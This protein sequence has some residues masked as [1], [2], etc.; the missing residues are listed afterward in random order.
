[1]CG[2]MRNLLKISKNSE[3]Q[4]SDVTFGAGRE[5]SQDQGLVKGYVW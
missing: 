3:A 2:Q 4:D 1:M 5:F